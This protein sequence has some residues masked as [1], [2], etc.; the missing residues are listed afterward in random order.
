MFKTFFETHAD[1]ILHDFLKSGDKLLQIKNDLDKAEVKTLMDTLEGQWK[2]IVTHAPVRLL[3]L[4]FKQLEILLRQEIKAADLEI[5]E[6]CQA[7]N[8]NKEDINEILKRHEAKFKH[9]NFFSTCESYLQ[10]LR[11]CSKEL[12]EKRVEDKSSIEDILDYLQS[13]WSN[14]TKKI[15][16]MNAKLTILPGAKENFERNFFQ[17][18]SW[19]NELELNSNSLFNNGLTSTSEYRRLLDKAKVRKIL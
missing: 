15:E 14:L 7:L 4:Q 11:M 1:E 13:Y 16:T 17:F 2:M 10:G 8:E 18:A 9:S 6:E 19:L 12:G 5:T 3:K